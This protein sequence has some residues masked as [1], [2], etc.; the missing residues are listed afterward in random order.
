MDRAV[1]P[2]PSPWSTA[3]RIIIRIVA[4]LQMVLAVIF[5]IGGGWLLTLGGSPYYALA[6]GAYGVSAVW[7]WQGRWR[8]VFLQTLVLVLTL[9]WSL[10]EV[11]FDF[12]PLVPRLVLPGILSASVLLMAWSLAPKTRTLG[13]IGGGIGAVVVA[14]LFSILAGAFV[15]HG[16]VTAPDLKASYQTAP[17]DNRPADW[18]AY[19]RT[20]E[21]R[22]FAPFDQ[23]NR[24]N[25]GGLKVAWTFRTGDIG[26]GEDQ[27]VPL[28][29]GERIYSCSRNNIV[30][31]L[32]AD[33][34][35]LLWRHDPKA[36]SPVWQRCRGLGYY[37]SDKATGAPQPT[38]VSVMP[39]RRRIIEPTVDARLIALDAE[40]GAR[41]AD[42]GQDGAVDLRVG[43]GPVKPGFYFMTSA[44]TI[45]R[46]LII[47]GGW[48]RDN[49]EIGEPSGVIR[50]FDVVTGNLVW[51]W[52]LGDPSITRLPPPGR[53]Y[54]RGT[55]NMW[56]TP[57]F[58]DQRGLLYLPLGNATPD[59][60]GAKRPAL[61]EQYSSS[62]VALDIA[63][64]RE[65]WRFQT[66]HH[67][68]WD[69]DVAAQPALVD[70]PDGR[71]GLRPAL[72]QT[73]KR[74]QLF[75]LDR[76]TGAPIAPVVEKPVPQTGGAPGD[77]LAK[78]QPYSVGMPAIGAERLTEAKMW[79]ASAIDQLWCRIE[80]RRMRYDGDFTP[81]GLTRSLEQPG[82]YGGF[83]WGSVSIDPV[84]GYAF[85][86]DIRLPSSVQLMPPDKIREVIAHTKGVA[87]RHGP[88]M[89]RGLP[90]GVVVLPMLSPLGAPCV[91]P[92]FGTLTAVDL[93]TR[94]IAWQTPVGTVRDTGLL[95][96]R[97]GLNMPIGMPT[98]GGSMAT[99]SGLVFFAGTQ[100]FYLRAFDARSGR[101]LWK[102]RLPVGSSSTP[103]TY[104]SPKTGRQYVLIS[105]GG[106]SGSTSRGDYVVAYALP[107]QPGGG[108]NF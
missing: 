12:W 85:M 41:C 28:Q 9:G 67:D 2:I 77:W 18:G 89:Q 16:L 108:A 88:A 80:F 62:I 1:D 45:V 32:D 21:G 64:G 36:K 24:D 71:G 26:K 33:T 97:T 104:V 68:L 79:G 96:L 92:P 65:R 75:L 57:S 43:M 105:A 58:D 61:A 25:V 81:P 102:G 90:Y 106:A 95:G 73:T 17:G 23:I 22:R 50:A 56:S 72:L 107:E 47:I 10:A 13:W 35:K 4:A 60:Y 6:G 69:Y 55:P 54:T 70:L 30:S 20:G 52:D 53:T 14:A 42:F 48:V 59:Y 19:G 51:A 87:N 40:T 29:I 7:L 94:R 34:G 8:G 39:C 98:I 78:T 37:D 83:N 63:T 49:Q 5:L 44:P 86:T 27:N 100:D 84:N 103:M 91:R 101:E 3:G 82:N 38:P 76:V 99:A 66:V 93:K 46:N 74:G 11:G 15:P 31:A